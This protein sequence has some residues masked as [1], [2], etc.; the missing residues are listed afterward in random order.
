[1][2]LLMYPFSGRFAIYLSSAMYIVTYLSSAMYIVV[3][4][5]LRD[6]QTAAFSAWHLLPSKAAPE[7]GPQTELFYGKLR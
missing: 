6:C 1:M 2:L 7:L 3:E 4:A 5:F